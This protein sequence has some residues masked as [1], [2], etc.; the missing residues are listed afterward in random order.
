MR[1]FPTICCLAF[2]SYSL[3][4]SLYCKQDRMPYRLMKLQG[5]L[6]GGNFGG[7]WSCVVMPTFPLQLSAFC[8]QRSKEANALWWAQHFVLISLFFGKKGVWWEKVPL[9]L[10]STLWIRRMSRIVKALWHR[11]LCLLKLTLQTYEVCWI[12][13]KKNVV[14]L[15]WV[16]IILNSLFI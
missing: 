4:I 3:C 8:F 13:S 15:T 7:V 1:F 10:I 6:A 11:V 5:I 2:F 16:F 9:W 14:M 12:S